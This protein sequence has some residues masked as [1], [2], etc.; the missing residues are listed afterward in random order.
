M[1]FA[2]TYYYIPYPDLFLH[3]YQYFDI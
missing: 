3:Y 1:H 2:A